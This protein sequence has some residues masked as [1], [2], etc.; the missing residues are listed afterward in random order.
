MLRS[1]RQCT[2]KS[3]QSGK[4]CK[5][6]AA[7]GK[8]VL[9]E[10]EQE[11]YDAFVKALRRDFQLNESSDEVSAQMAAM[12]FVQYERAIKLGNA[13]AADIY[14]TMVLRHLKSMKA[15]KISREGEKTT[16]LKTTPAEWAAALIK[17]V[18][19]AKEE[20]PADAKDAASKRKGTPHAD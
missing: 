11:I 4:R 9:D 14:D 17:E 15:T 8:R 10:Q 2:A 7:P 18:R 5:R 1:R 19:A 16:R 20:R 13:K 12:A 6:P 3:K